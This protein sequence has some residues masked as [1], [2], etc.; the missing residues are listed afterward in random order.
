MMD[1]LLHKLRFFRFCHRLYHQK[2]MSEVWG[3]HWHIL[4]WVEPGS[5]LDNAVLAELPHS[6]DP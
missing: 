6:S 1:I 5:T 3:L 2:S 4:F